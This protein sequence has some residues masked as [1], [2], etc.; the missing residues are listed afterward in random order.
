VLNI[1]PGP[2][3]DYVGDLRDL[4]SFADACAQEIYAS[5]VLEH[6]SQQDVPAV[7]Q[8]LGRLLAPGG[9]L[10]VSVPDLEVLSHTIVTPHATAEMK[11]HAMRMMFGGQTDAHDFHYFGWTFTFMCHFLKQAGFARVERV[12]SFGL[13]DD[14]SDFKPWGFPI[15]LN[16]I[17]T[18]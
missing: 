18:R 14:T 16:V 13:F 12:E 3:V 17:A 8:G 9:R 5:H 11:F 15:S 10:M 1:Q 7:L 6:V 4:S 2:A